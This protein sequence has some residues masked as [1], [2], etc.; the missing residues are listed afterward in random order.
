MEK[1]DVIVIGAGSAGLGNAG[2]ANTIGLKTLMVEEH[3]DNFGGDCTNFGCVPSKALIHVA[4]LFDGARR[5]QDFG[6]QISGK[7]DMKKV[8]A[9]IHKHQAHIK[10]EED[11]AH[12]RAAG[13]DVEIGRARFLDKKTIEVNGKKFTARKILLCTGSSPRYLNIPGIEAVTTFTNETI[14]FD[15]DT[16]PEKFLVI[17]G[18]AIGCEMAQA[19]QRLGSQVT[20][21]DRGDRLLKNERPEISK[22]LEDCFR[23]EGIQI[24]HNTEVSEFKN[25]EAILKAK[26][27]SANSIKLD[28]VLLAVGRVVNVKNMGLDKA[29]IALTDRGKIKVDEYLRSTNKKVFVIGDAAGKYMFSHGAEKMVRQLWRNL[30]I[31]IAKQKNSTHNLSWVTFTDPEVATFGYSEQEMNDRRISY[32]RQDQTFSEDDRAIVDEYPYG[33]VSIW[34]DNRGALGDRT[35]KAATMI[36]PKAGDLIQ[37]LQLAA[38]TGIPIGEMTKRVYPYPVASRINQKTL[39]GVM[40]K[41]YTS[42]KKKMARVAFRLFN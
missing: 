8:L 22:I 40:D 37:E 38:E 18:G 34:T 11:A 25:G 27:G 35:I 28:A 14:F 4:K 19:F 16:L 6:L 13:I 7:A 17:G 29:S 31:P 21:V 23:K 12:H 33:R 10:G 41:S 15:C 36:A 30:L 26:D 9:Y 1:Y 32:Y 20:I 42:F 39:R 24:L 5:A 3:E 2:V